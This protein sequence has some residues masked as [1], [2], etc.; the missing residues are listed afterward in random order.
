VDD[1]GTILTAATVLRGQTQAIV[2]WRNK[3]YEAKVMG[4]DQR[5]NLALLK[6]EDQTPFLK[7]S[8]ISPKIGSRVLA[9]GFPYDGSIAVEH[10]YIWESDP[11]RTPITFATTHICSSVRVQPGQSGSPFLNMKG[12]VMGVVTFAT[13]DGKASYALPID[14]AQRIQQ[15]LAKNHSAKHGWVGMTI[16]VKARK[17]SA[18]EDVVIRGVYHGQPAHIATIQPGDI[19]R[20]IGDKEIHT[21]ADVMNATIYL[22][23]DSTINFTI[24]RDAIIKEFSVKVTPRPSDQSLTN[25]KLLSPNP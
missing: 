16:E 4:E 7:S 25:I 12:E 9:V 24:E 20:K 6:I 23:I 14:T 13:Q 1:H 3:A 15:D 11:V 18:Q 8:E 5:T 22:P 2:Y 21:P 10:G 17:A 19:L